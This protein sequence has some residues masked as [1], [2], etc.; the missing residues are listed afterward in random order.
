MRN[1]IQRLFVVSDAKPEYNTSVVRID[2]FNEDFHAT[3]VI[4]F[5]D[6]H[7]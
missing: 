1:D 3:R 6:I 5:P 7:S 2:I 4:Q